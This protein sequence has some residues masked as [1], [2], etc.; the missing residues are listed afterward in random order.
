MSSLAVQ[1]R[2]SVVDLDRTAFDEVCA[3][4]MRHAGAERWPDALIAIPTGG[5]HVAQAMAKAAGGDMPVLSLTCRRPSSKLKPGGSA[6]RKM[7]SGLPRPIVDRLRLAEH[8]LLTR[9]PATRPAVPYHFVQQ[10]IEA[11]RD[12]MA[13]APDRLSLLVVDDAVDSGA[14]LAQ[15]VEAVRRYAPPGASVRSAAV[16]VTTDWPLIQPEYRMF[17]RQLCRFPWSMDA[18]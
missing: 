16:T 17:H 3:E 8:A 11:L 6:V 9:R 5:W 4:L 1:D 13:N 18:R 7:V 14:T 2:R 12:W 10:E 15:V